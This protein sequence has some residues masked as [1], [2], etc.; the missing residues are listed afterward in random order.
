M[1]KTFVFGKSFES[2]LQDLDRIAPTS[3]CPVCPTCD[4]SSSSPNGN[5]DDDDEPGN[6]DRS[7]SILWFAVAIVASM[8]AAMTTIM[9]I[10][11]Q[12]SGK[13]PGV[14][15]RVIVPEYDLELREA[16]Y[17]DHPEDEK[18]T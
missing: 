14:A 11:R 10:V 15:D 2:S 7:S 3:G 17:T 1:M 6:Y 8:S 16:R 12:K 9:M 5:D 13:R 18:E 4:G